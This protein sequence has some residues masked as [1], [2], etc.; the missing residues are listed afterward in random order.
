VECASAKEQELKKDG[1]N[2][3]DTFPIELR[4][5][6]S[7]SLSLSL[8]LFLSLSLSLCGVDGSVPLDIECSAFHWIWVHLNVVPIGAEQS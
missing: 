7:L 2:K 4:R 6:L 1:T 5:S 8:F 3:R